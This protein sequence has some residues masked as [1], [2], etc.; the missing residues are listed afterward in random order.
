MRSS[1]LVTLASAFVLFS[2]S[3]A[4]D[5]V[6]PDVFATAT[7]PESNPF[8]HIMNG[9]Q[10]SLL[11]NIENKSGQNITLVNAAGSVHHTETSQLVKNLTTTKYGLF[12]PEGVNIELPYA[13]YSE[14]KPGDIRLNVWLEHTIDGQNYR[15]TAYDSV[16][17]IVEPEKSIFD[18]KLLSTYLIVTVIFGGLSYLT[19]L[20]FVPQSR[21]LRSKK[22]TAPSVSSPVG[23]VTATGASGY[24]EEW[25]PE[26]HLRK[27][28]KG[29]ATSGDEVSGSEL[30]GAEGRKRKGRK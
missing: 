27:S 24:Q 1:V 14:F 13:F 20:N 29:G 6:E 10:N 21:K 12:L 2:A 5:P 8:G 18:I 11:L 23:P 26:H 19:Y 22:V 9:E 16:V 15:V 7:F 3:A 28:K 25:I 4:E 30:S 17:T